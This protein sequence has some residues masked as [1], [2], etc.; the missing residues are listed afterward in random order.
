MGAGGHGRRTKKESVTEEKGSAPLPLLNETVALMNLIERFN[1]TRIASVH[2]HRFDEGLG[3]H[4]GQD[5]PGIFVDPVGGFDTSRDPNL[6][7][8]ASRQSVEASDRSLRRE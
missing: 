8:I 6:P 7:A 3:A 5:R 4:R 2:A 1:P